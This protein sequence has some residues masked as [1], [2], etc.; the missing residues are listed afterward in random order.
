MQVFSVQ[1]FLTQWLPSPNFLKLSVPG[2]LRIFRAL[3]SDNYDTDLGNFDENDENDEKNDQK[4]Y[5]YYDFLSNM[6]QF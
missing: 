5:K 4:T 6:Y 2:D 1:T 3:A